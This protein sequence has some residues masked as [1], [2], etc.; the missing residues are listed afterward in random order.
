MAPNWTDRARRRRADARRN[1]PN[2]ALGRAGIAAARHPTVPQPVIISQFAK[3][4]AGEILDIRLEDFEGRPMIDMR[5]WYTGANGALKRSGKGIFLSVHKLP[6]LAAA[7]TKALKT[8]R[9][10]GLIEPTEESA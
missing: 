6:E 9:E 4:S 5:V 1:D 3:N 7:I 10:I 8:A 2:A